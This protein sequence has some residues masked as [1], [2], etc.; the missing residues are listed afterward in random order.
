M[1]WPELGAP[2]PVAHCI[3]GSA[4]CTGSRG[5]RSRRGCCGGCFRALLGKRGRRGL[6]GQAAR[7]ARDAGPGAT[8][9]ARAPPANVGPPL[10]L[11]AKIAAR[12]GDPEAIDTLVTVLKKRLCGLDEQGRTLLFYAVRGTRGD[13]GS[14]EPAGGSMADARTSGRVFIAGCRPGDAARHLVQRHGFSVN[15][16][17]HDTGM[18]PLMEAARYGNCAAAL[19]LLQLGADWQ[20]RNANGH[21]A[22]DVARTRLPEYLSLREAMCSENQWEAVKAR[23]DK[24]RDGVVSLLAFVEQQGCLGNLDALKA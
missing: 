5:R 20:L 9:V 10:T 22:L 17:V 2:W 13:N 21:S 8:F 12:K 24:D 16:Q 6:R 7:S 4:L 19:A 11:Q 15:F 14:L 3:M 23:V 1:Y 18:T